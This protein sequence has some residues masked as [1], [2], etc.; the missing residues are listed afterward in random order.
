MGVG[1]ATIG[2][3]VDK[4]L[5]FIRG[6]QGASSSDQCIGGVPYVKVPDTRA[7]RVNVNP[8]NMIPLAL[9]KKI[10]GRAGESRLEAWNL[11]SLSRASS[12][13]GEF[14]VLLPANRV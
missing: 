10:W 11:V 14:A 3:L 13:I 1:E 12:N 6:D 5:V 8:T 9:A 4:K 7:M 2:E